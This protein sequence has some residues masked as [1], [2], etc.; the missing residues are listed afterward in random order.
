MQKINQLVELERQ[1]LELQDK[2]TH[3][4]TELIKRK[5]VGQTYVSV[6]SLLIRMSEI[7]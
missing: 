5:Q 6:F 1:E 7:S 2:L 4:T 3:T